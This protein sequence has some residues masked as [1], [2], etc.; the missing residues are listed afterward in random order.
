MYDDDPE[1]VQSIATTNGTENSAPT[2]VPLTGL[3]LLPPQKGVSIW[4][5]NTEGTSKID[6]TAAKFTLLRVL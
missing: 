5:R 6:A 2:S 3:F 1:D 4:V